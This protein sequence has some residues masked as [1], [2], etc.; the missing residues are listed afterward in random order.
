MPECVRIPGASEKI[1]DKNRKALG[2]VPAKALRKLVFVD[3]AMDG[4]KT[5][6]KRSSKAE[7]PLAFATRFILA[8]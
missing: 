7:A 3:G 5:P 2:S 1:D 8:P 6:G 4:H